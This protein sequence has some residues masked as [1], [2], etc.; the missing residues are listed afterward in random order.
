MEQKEKKSIHYYMRGLHRDIGFFLIGLTLIYSI[1]GVLL[2]Y[3]DTDFLKHQKLIEKKL[4]PNIEA[5]Q[6]GGILHIRDFKFIKSEGAVVY[7]N[8]GTYN[9]AT[10]VVKYTSQE[11]PAWL[12]VFNNLHKSSS[13]DSVHLFATIYGI[14]LLFLAIS[15]LF[16]FKPKTKMFYR[17]VLIA[18]AGLVF[19]A[20]LL[21]L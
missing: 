16:I 21:L 7:F 17:G 2:I 18:M 8:K 15:S 1:S 4:S 11:L 19:A 6:L 12:S 5:S 3:R 20:I 10:G 13:K 9:T 14:L